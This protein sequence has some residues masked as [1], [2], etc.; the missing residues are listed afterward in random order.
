MS[1]ESLD[2]FADA[3]GDIS[4]VSRATETEY[5]DGYKQVVYN[6]RQRMYDKVTFSYSRGREKTQLVYD[7]LYRSLYNNKPFHYRFN[8]TDTAKLYIVSKDSLRHAHVSGLK[9]TVTATFEEWN[10]LP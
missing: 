6:G 9:W 3:G 2:V 5:A 1:Y 7:L 10:G 8:G 4:P